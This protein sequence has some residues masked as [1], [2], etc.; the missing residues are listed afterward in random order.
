[1]NLR[2][3]T[4]LVVMLGLCPAASYI[5]LDNLFTPRHDPCRQFLERAQADLKTMDGTVWAT[6]ANSAHESATKNLTGYLACRA[7]NDK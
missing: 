6:T 3:K 1:M 5:L 2:A 7:D 4:V